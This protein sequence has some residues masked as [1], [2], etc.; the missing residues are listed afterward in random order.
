[1]DIEDSRDMLQSEN[2]SIFGDNYE[3][4]HRMVFYSDHSM[5]HACM[6]DDFDL[7]WFRFSRVL[8]NHLY[9]WNPVEWYDKMKVPGSCV[10]SLMASIIKINDL[11]PP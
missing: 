1:M 10:L 4:D 11:I 2:V 5:G 6:K 7:I 3:A 8:L 9:K